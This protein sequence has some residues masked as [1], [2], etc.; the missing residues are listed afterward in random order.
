M[1]VSLGE[2]KSEFKSGLGPERINKLTDSVVCQSSSK[3]PVL[4]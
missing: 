1:G 2:F 4:H 3:S